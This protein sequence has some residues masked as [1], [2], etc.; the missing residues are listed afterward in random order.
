M[1]IDRFPTVAVFVFSYLLEICDTKWTKEKV[2]FVPPLNGKLLRDYFLS[3]AVIKS[4]NCC[5]QKVCDG[6]GFAR[7]L[8]LKRSNSFFNFNVVFATATTSNSIRNL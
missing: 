5:E 7:C 8:L 1:D 6:N 3:F 4:N 2:C